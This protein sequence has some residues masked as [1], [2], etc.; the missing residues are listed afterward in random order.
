M[1]LNRH[2]LVVAVTVV[3]AVLWLGAMVV[4]MEWIWT[5]K[6]TPGA[7]PS[8]LGQWPGSSLVSPSNDRATLIMFLH[9][10]CS[11]SKASLVELQQIASQHSDVLSL[12][13]LI[14]DAPGALPG[15]D[16]TSTVT[17]ARQVPNATIV[18]DRDGAEARRFGAT[19][20]GH[21]VVYDAAG[22]LQFSGGITG[23][24][25]HVGDNEG[26]RSVVALLRG[27][28]AS[29]SMHPTFGCGLFDRDEPPS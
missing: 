17:R 23:A 6:T 22:T 21:V 26:L 29:R 20:S 2:R 8:V 12:W 18:L 14:N 15:W 27:D 3:G 5:Y 7:S 25:G 4:A 13:V 9:P 19:T 16:S 11:C 28:R 10:R 1:L 24:R